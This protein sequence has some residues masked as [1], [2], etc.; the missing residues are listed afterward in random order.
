MPCCAIF[1]SVFF[2][3]AYDLPGSR[4]DGESGQRGAAFAAARRRI[5]LRIREHWYAFKAAFPVYLQKIFP[6]YGA[7]AIRES[8]QAE[9]TASERITVPEHG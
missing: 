6:K 1:L 3:G 2:Q 8:E 9:E 5:Q 7:E 4:S